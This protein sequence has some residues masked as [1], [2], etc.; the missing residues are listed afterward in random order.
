MQKNACSLNTGIGKLNDTNLL[1]C[2]IKWVV[3]RATDASGMIL[4][5]D[6][7]MKYVIS[8]GLGGSPKECYVSKIFRNTYDIWYAEIRNRRD[9]TVA[10]NVD[11]NMII[12]YSLY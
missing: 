10:K 8:V 11:V 12:F 3:D 5:G 9:D 1:N 6:A 7:T 4:L 2:R